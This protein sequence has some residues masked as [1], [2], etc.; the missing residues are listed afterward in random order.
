MN[1]I[2]YH[3]S[4]D[5]ESR[6]FFSTLSTRCVIS[7]R[8]SLVVFVF[9]PLPSFH[10]YSFLVPYFFF[11]T[12]APLSAPRGGVII[13]CRRF[14]DVLLYVVCRAHPRDVIIAPAASVSFLTFA[15]V[16]QWSKDHP[17]EIL[18][19]ARKKKK[20]PVYSLVPSSDAPSWWH[21]VRVPVSP[22]S[23]TRSDSFHTL[24]G[25]TMCV[26]FLEGITKKKEITYTN[27]REQS[28]W[29]HRNKK[30]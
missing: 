25:C 21:M 14:T 8:V 18:E 7:R 4:D 1:V 26:F 19:G 17:L 22:P 10:P 3:P 23:I 11:F 29:L 24:L 30:E 27:A 6:F 28:W 13:Y 12:A 15:A 2:N 16:I 20:T 5:E 9:F